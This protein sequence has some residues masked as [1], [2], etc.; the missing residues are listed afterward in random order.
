MYDESELLGK[1]VSELNLIC[2]NSEDFK[3][4]HSIISTGRSWSGEIESCKKDGTV[5]WLKTN[6]LPIIGKD[7]KV[8]SYLILTS[9]ITAIK[10][11]MHQKNLIMAN[12]ARSEARYRAL[13]ENQ[14]DLMSLCNS[15]GVRLFVNEKYCEFMGMAEKDLV[16]TNILEL[17]FGGLS[18]ELVSKVLEMT[19]QNSEVSGIFRLVNSK[20][21]QVWVSVFVRG[22]FDSFG[23]LIEILTI[24]R[25]VTEL[26]NAEI[27]LSKYVEDLERIAFITAHKVRAPIA[28]MLG[29]VEL[30][31]LNAI[32]SDQW[33]KVFGS[34]DNC[35]RHLD[36]YT[37][38]LGAFINLRQSGST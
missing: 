36:L 25:D 34:F 35:L 4:I 5:I 33:G 23:N 38:E 7:G 22:I 16:G 13:V 2:F 26:K 1:P 28:S 9:D 20:G 21:E 18:P 10:T 19:I 27:E 6:I 11:A 17:P 14:R 29:L 31:R 12:L 15:A 30:L 37:Q 8:C 24:G 3:E 32:D